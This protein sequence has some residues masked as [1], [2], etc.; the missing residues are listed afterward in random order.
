[1]SRFD[2]A[3]WFVA[4]LVLGLALT[5]LGPPLQ[6]CFPAV[7]L[8]QPQACAAERPAWLASL[9]P[10][11]RFEVEHRDLL[12]GIL[13]LA[14]LGPAILASWARRLRRQRPSSLAP[15]RPAP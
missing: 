15:D 5:L 11:E 8:D 12:A 9:S 14:S 13:I 6:P 7:G 2:L 4:L 3:V 10:L 1:M